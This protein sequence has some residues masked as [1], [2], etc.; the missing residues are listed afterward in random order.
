VQIWIL[1]FAILTIAGAWLGWRRSPLYSRK[2]TLKLIGAVLLTVAA[3]VGASIAILKLPIAKSPTAQLVLMG[4]LIIAVGIGATAGLIRITDSHVAQLPP[5]VRIVNAE[6]HKIQVW[7]CR[8]L[9]YLLISGTAILAIPS[10]WAW[11]PA[12]PGVLVL[13]GG[14]PS[15]VALYMRARRLDLGMSQV[16]AAPW[17]HWRYSPEEW[18]AWARNQ[19]AWERSK[20]VKI[21]WKRDWRK[22]LKAA[23]ILAAIFIGCA[24]VMVSGSVSDRLIAAAACMAFFLVVILCVSLATRGAPER[25]NRRLLAAPLEAVL[26]DEGVFCDGTFSPWILSGSYL[27]EAT[28]PR[29]PPAR[30][31]LVFRNFNGSSATLVAR[32]I[33]IPPGHESDVAAIQQRL[34][35]QCPKA[36]VRLA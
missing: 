10:Q 7:I 29:D 27:V 8:I 6:R 12:A 33:P 30:L 35:A 18:Q 23:A 4:L 21:D 1:I 36:T 3:I 14:G 20:Q 26:G 31:E 34:H 16:L 19:L 22:V 28:S 13:L 5:S 17:A 24:L 15:L 32:R 9:A 2:T 11:L 25:R